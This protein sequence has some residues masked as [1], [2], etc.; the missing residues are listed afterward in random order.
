MHFATES[1][2]EAKHQDK[3]PLIPTFWQE[4]HH[5]WDT[6]VELKGGI[7]NTILMK[8]RNGSIHFSAILL[9][10]MMPLLSIMIFYMMMKRAFTGHDDIDQMTRQLEEKNRQTKARM[11]LWIKAHPNFRRKVRKWE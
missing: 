10:Y 2:H 8:D 4:I 1:F 7:L 3:M 11:E 5:M 9:V 6:E